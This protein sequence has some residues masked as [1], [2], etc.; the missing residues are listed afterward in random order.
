MLR[1]PSKTQKR[2]I[3]CGISL[4]C[5]MTFPFLM[6]PFYDLINYKSPLG[7]TWH[8]LNKPAF[9]V[10]IFL[11]QKVHLTPPGG[12][13]SFIAFYASCVFMQWFLPFAIVGLF[14]TR[15]SGQR[16]KTER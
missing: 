14:W 11:T 7:E 10:F 6:L 15:I 16:R 4:G 8:L 13:F 2:I 9:D 12:F 5:L 1:H 3:A